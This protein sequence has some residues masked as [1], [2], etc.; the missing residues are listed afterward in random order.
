MDTT[1]TDDFSFLD[2]ILESNSDTDNIFCVE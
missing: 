1:D 2:P